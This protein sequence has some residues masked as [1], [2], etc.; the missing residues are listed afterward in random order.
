MTHPADAPIA[1]PQ[2]AL[3]A[4]RQATKN[5]RV[6]AEPPLTRR[7][8]RMEPAE[9]AVVSAPARAMRATS[10]TMYSQLVGA[11]NPRSR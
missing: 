8:M 11:W 4:A 9:A 3:K 6:R 7:R 10:A 2:A 5:R 1:I